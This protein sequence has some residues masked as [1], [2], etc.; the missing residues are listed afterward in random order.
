MFQHLCDADDL[1]YCVMVYVSCII[2]ASKV[3]LNISHKIIICQTESTKL[4]LY[5]KSDMSDSC[6]INIVITNYKK[7]DNKEQFMY[8][9]RS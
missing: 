2:T 1:R 6:R 4:Y 7:R 9:I 3:K 5:Q 8:L